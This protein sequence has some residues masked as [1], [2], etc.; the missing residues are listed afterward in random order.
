MPTQ[1]GFYAHVWVNECYFSSKGEYGSMHDQTSRT[2]N[3]QSSV[4]FLTH[5]VAFFVYV[6]LSL[7]AA[8]SLYLSAISVGIQPT[9]MADCG[10]AVALSD[11]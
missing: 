11:V 7:E 3:A 1:S 6:R 9:E 5:S 8:P 4:S 10:Q 2:H